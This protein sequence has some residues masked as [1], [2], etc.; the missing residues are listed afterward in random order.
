[1]FNKSKKGGFMTSLMKTNGQLTSSMPSLLNDFF[2]DDLFR[3]PFLSSRLQ[4][5]T[6]PSVNIRETDDAFQVEVAAPGMKRE[7]FKVELDN[8]MLRISSE[9]RSKE[10][11]NDDTYLLKEF[12]YQSFE[13]T[14]ELRSDY[15]ESDKIQARYLDGILQINL[16]KKEQV[17]RKPARQIK[18][19]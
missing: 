18:I 12:S 5:A 13:R 7:D 2:A 6:L 19:A 10:D 15:V 3:L 17:R 16:P 9:T 11:R 1:M 4:G 8:N 14:F